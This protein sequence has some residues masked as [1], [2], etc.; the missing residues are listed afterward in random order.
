MIKTSL[1]VLAVIAGTSFLLVGCGS[2]TTTKVVVDP[3]EAPTEAPTD[4]PT[5]GPTSGPTPSPKTPD[6]ELLPPFGK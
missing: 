6:N 1:K 2:S 3:T 5:A 4:A